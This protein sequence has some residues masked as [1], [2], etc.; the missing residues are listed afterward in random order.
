MHIPIQVDYGVRA[1]IDL[2]E[3]QGEGSIRAHDIAARKGIPEP[4]LVQVLH[5]LNK[6]GF[7]KSQRGPKGGHSLA[8]NAD[9]ISMSMVMS[10]LNTRQTL[11]GCLD[12]QAWC[13]QYSSC[14]QREIWREIQESIERILANTSIASL[15]DRIQTREARVAGAWK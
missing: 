13:G 2:T 10:N 6:A 1:L 9:K 4:Y 3:H 8:K 7:V 11:V 5:T 14:G 15:V 12:D